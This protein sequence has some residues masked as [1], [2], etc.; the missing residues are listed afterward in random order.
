MNRMLGLS[1]PRTSTG[2]PC[3]GDLGLG[4]PCLWREGHDTSAPPQTCWRAIGGVGGEEQGAGDGRLLLHGLLDCVS[5]REDWCHIWVRR[6][7]RGISKS[8]EQ[9]L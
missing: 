8:L 7:G 6:S 3:A 5:T 4:V 1:L 9:E 2:W